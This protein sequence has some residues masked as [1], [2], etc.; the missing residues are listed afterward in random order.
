LSPLGVS[1]VALQLAFQLQRIKNEEQVLGSLFPEYETYRLHT[2][3]LL[4]GLY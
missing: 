1:I 3:R 4:P 2:V